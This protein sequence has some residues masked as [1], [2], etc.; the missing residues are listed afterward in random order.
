[1]WRMLS[2]SYLKSK[3]REA[4]LRKQQRGTSLR[5]SGGGAFPA[6]GMAVQ[7]PWGALTW[8]FQAQPGGQ[9]GQRGEGEGERGG[10]SERRG[11]AGSGRPPAT[12]GAWLLLCQAGLAEGFDQ[13]ADGNSRVHFCH[14]WRSRAHFLDRSWTRP[15][16]RAVAE[17]WAPGVAADT[18]TPGS[19]VA[20]WPRDCS[21]R[22]SHL[23][24]FSCP[25]L[26]P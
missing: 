26:L 7:R 15:S 6:E 13:R 14:R 8:C 19:R 23:W 9:C 10:E 1:M 22:A 3:I 2:G 25:P 21:A 4:S 24:P 16:Q 11:G 20:G 17:A 12:A 18:S 5:L